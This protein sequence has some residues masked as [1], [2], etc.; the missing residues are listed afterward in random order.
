[1]KRL[2]LA[3]VI[4][5]LLFCYC[6]AE[7][8]FHCDRCG[9]KAYNMHDIFIQD[10]NGIRINYFSNIYLCEKCYEEF[11]KVLENFMKGGK[12]E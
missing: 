3:L 8:I 12:N 10:F 4:I 5:C 11:K 2:F 7:E 1:M 6:K 9:E